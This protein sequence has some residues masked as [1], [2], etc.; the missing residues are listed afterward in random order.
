MTKPQI[1]KKIVVISYCNLFFTRTDTVRSY[2]LT[3]GDTL[4][5]THSLPAH[6]LIVKA[7]PR[8][9][10][11]ISDNIALDKHFCGPTTQTTTVPRPKI[12]LA[13]SFHRSQSD[14]TELI[15]HIVLFQTGSI[16]NAVLVASFELF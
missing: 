1:K 7:I 10:D 11:R 8:M 4:E 16:F 3:A 12:H 15:P 14:H 6:P 9:G 2:T 5:Y 13:I